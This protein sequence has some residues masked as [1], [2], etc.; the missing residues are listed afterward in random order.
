LTW[1]ANFGDTQIVIVNEEETIQETPNV[2]LIATGWVITAFSMLH[3][4]P[5]QFFEF[6]KIRIIA[7]RIFKN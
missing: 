6:L 1:N 2:Y 7:K 5:K 3:F 4:Y